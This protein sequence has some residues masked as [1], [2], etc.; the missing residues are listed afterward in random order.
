MIGLLLALA[1]LVQPADLPAPA[2][3][4][5]SEAPKPDPMARYLTDLEKAGVLT[6]DKQPATLERLRTELAA[7]EDDLVTGNAEVASVRLFRIVESPRYV[8]FEYAPDFANAEF[9]LA[10][11]LI[12]AGG[13]KSAERYLLRVLGR[14][15]KSP[16]F[17]PAYRALVD[18]ALETHEQAAILAVLDHF[19]QD[20][21]ARDGG[22]LP[23]DSEAEHA[24]L[25]AKVAY[26]GGDAGPRRGAV[27]RG[28]P[29]VALL[30]RRA[31]LPRPHPGP[32]G[33]YAAARRS[34]C[35]IVEQIDQDRFTFFI[36]GRYYGIKDLAFLALGRIAHE[37][38]EVR[39]RLLLL[40]P[41]PRGLGAPPRRPVRGLVV[42]VPEGGVR[43]GG[44]VP[45]GVRPV[46]R[47]DAAR[48]GR[49]A[50]ARD[51]RSQV[52]R[53]RSG[54][55][56][57]GRAGQD[58]RADRGARSPPCSRTR[59]SEPRSTSACSASGRSARRGTRSSSC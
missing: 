49:A 28:R 52:L 25:A 41:R 24:Y 18:V 23:R 45:R 19:A 37:Q 10:R 4:R 15:T 22:A 16:F 29:P 14:G 44:R 51:D 9:T 11:A 46:V 32:Q 33:H 59:R 48:P 20:W 39:R 17:A 57:A 38:G 43:G 2:R 42:D 6:A 35:E 5:A 47:Q 56:D 27:R 1:L 53:V 12:R 26:E 58:L 13:Y 3:T 7:A 50:A 55:H 34:L 54:A 8:Q 21:Q 36:D 30:R 40:L 31:L